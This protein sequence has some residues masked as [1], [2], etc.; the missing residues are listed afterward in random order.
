[1]L[2]VDPEPDL[3]VRQKDGEQLDRTDAGNKN[4][5][6][7]MNRNDRA[8]S[9]LAVAFTTAKAMVHLH[10]VGSTEWP[11]GLASSVVKSLMQKYRP[12]DL[13]SGI[14]YENALWSFK[15]KKNQDPTE[16]LPKPTRNTE[17]TSPMKRN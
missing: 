15:L 7:A 10:K 16:F 17:L 2:N 13:I 5:I 4:A 6:D 8:L 11:D 9:N 1:V 14:E 12:Q 3:P